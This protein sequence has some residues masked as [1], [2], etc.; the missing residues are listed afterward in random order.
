MKLAA[1]STTSS[2]AP[3]PMC[4]RPCAGIPPWYGI[5]GEGW[6]LS[7]HV[8]TRYVKVTFLNAHPW[9][10]FRPA[11]GKDPRFALGRYL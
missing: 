3:C 7:Y 5:E 11:A 1:A 4:A 2:S 9:I 8:F 10:R 6:F